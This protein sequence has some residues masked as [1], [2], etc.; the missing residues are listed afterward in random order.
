MLIEKTLGENEQ[1]N[2]KYMPWK[3]QKY[4]LGV[5][6]QHYI[7]PWFAKGSWL[8]AKLAPVELQPSVNVHFI[9]QFLGKNLEKGSI[10]S[11]NVIGWGTQQ[12]KNSERRMVLTCNKR[13]LELNK[14]RKDAFMLDIKLALSPLEQFVVSTCC[15]LSMPN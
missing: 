15:F 11:R 7:F 14:T 2:F 12:I 3:W 13:E 5:I 10:I 6:S 8:E 4:S 9:Y 1:L